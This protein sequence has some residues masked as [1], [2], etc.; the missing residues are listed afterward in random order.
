[1]CDSSVGEVVFRLMFIVF[2][3]FLIMVFSVCVS[4]V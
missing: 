3:V 2:I 4:L 1:M